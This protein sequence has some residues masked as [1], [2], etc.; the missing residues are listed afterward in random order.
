MT[1]ST[2]TNL[3][4]EVVTETDDQ[5]K[6][7]CQMAI[8]HMITGRVIRACGKPADYLVHMHCNANSPT[9]YHEESSNFMCR[10]C[11]HESQVAWSFCKMHDVPAILSYTSL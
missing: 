2:D 8:K 1:T 7:Q 3:D 4:I 10:E 9:L 6:P 5:K 11:L